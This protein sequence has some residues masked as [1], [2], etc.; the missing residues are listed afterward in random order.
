MNCQEASEIKKDDKFLTVGQILR[1]RSYWIKS[2]L[3]TAFIFIFMVLA[4]KFLAIFSFLDPIGDALA[5]YQVTDQVFS[6][7][8]WRD[9]YVPPDTNILIV[10]VGNL[11]RAGIAQQLNI[12]N[13]FHPK[14]IGIDLIFRNLKP[15]TLG[16][17][18]LAQAMANTQNLIVYQKLLSPGDDDYWYDA[19]YSHP[20]FSLGNP[21][22]AF[23]NLLN[24]T[25][26]AKQ[27]EF[28][29][30]RSFNPRQYLYDSLTNKVDTVY[31]FAVEMARYLKPDNVE[32]F[33]ARNNDEEVVNYTGNV[34]D[35]G[36]TKFGT[37]FYALDT[38]QVLDT[39][40]TEDLV[41]DRIV[42]M[43]VMGS[44]FN[45]K[46][47]VEDK[48][49][50]PLN[51]RPAGRANPDMFGVVVHANIISMILENKYIDSMGSTLSTIIAFVICFI[52]ILVF[53]LIYYK[54]SE[55]YDGLTKLLQLAQALLFFF[56]IIVFFSL[57]RYKLDLTLTI[58]L[59][60]LAGDVLEVYYGFV[61]NAYCRLLS[62]FKKK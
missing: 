10:N 36:R 21:K 58:I 34:I 38:Y 52:N 51:S 50:T 28:K 25:P 27:F 35:Y 2:I 15:D 33:L 9:P 39:L 13:S 11:D 1:K 17:M 7:T 57:Y 12:L 24:E 40:F 54:M 48:Y 49:F 30:C 22:T 55:W 32:K 31:A 47:T 16:D 19:E 53:T 60:L 29:S 62:Y 44:S 56:L 42:L 45:D 46:Y 8:T 3:A 14:V 26:D 23:V 5:D 18:I 37:R 43:G 6:D 4:G 41:K 61:M 59:V 20:I